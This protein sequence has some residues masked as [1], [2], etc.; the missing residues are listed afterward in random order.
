MGDFCSQNPNI[1]LIPPYF[2]PQIPYNSP[3]LDR[4]I[5]GII[6][7][8]TAATTAERLFGISRETAYGLWL[9]GLRLA[10]SY[11]QESLSRK[12]PSSQLN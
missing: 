8:D 7:P 5:S 11:C 4:L 10:K 3:F 6:A 12:I 9:L 1:S 2:H